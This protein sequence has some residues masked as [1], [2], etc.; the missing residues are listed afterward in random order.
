MLFR[1]DPTLGL[2]SQA[3]FNQGVA[4]QDTFYSGVSDI[5]QGRKQLST[6]D[7]YLQEWR[8][9]AG[10]KMRAEFQDAIEASKK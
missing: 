6:L 5:I 8:Q 7:G 3:G 1:S 2:Y 10:D 9:K 4:A